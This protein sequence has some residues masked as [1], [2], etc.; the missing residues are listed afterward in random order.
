M[1][2]VY[3][4]D[5]GM[6]VPLLSVLVA[7]LVV[8]SMRGGKDD[9][10]WLMLPLAACVVGLFFLYN[11]NSYLPL[12]DYRLKETVVKVAVLAIATLVVSISVL[13]DPETETSAQLVLRGIA[14]MLLSFS[15]VLM[16]FSTDVRMPYARLLATVIALFSFVLAFVYV[17]LDN[18]PVRTSIYTSFTGIALFFLTYFVLASFFQRRQK[19][20]QQQQVAFGF[21]I[22]P[23]QKGRKMV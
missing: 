18:K 19:K 23:L 12:V 17:C 20:Q 3:L 11:P 6:N 15:A 10:W 4:Q 16:A 1:R 22:A 5:I 7:T 14:V 21:N 8:V 9:R 2:Q 13:M